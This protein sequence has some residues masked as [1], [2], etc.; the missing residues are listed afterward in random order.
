MTDV[1]D[2]LLHSLPDEDPKTGAAVTKSEPARPSHD[3]VRIGR[4]IGRRGWRDHHGGSYWNW[5]WNRDRWGHIDGGIAVRC[6]DNDRRWGD[7]SHTKSGT[8]IGVVMVMASAVITL[9]RL[10]SDRQNSPENKCGQRS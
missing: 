7:D 1:I 8:S 5:W 2:A 4:R 10:Q 9:S 6:R 3:P